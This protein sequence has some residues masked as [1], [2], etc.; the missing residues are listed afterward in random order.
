MPTLFEKLL[1]LLT[2]VPREG[3]GAADAKE[4]LSLYFTTGH[5]STEP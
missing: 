4:I 3:E 1:V 5:F 2:N